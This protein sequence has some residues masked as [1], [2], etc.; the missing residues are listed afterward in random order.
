MSTRIVIYG[1]SGS[2]KTTMAREVAASLGIAHLDL[3]GITWGEGIVR[4]PLAETV[5]LLDAFIDAHESWVIEGCYGDVVEVAA[6]R[7]TELRFLNPGV[8]TCIARCL[9]RPFEPAKFATMEAQNEMLVQLLPWVRAYETRE[10]EY[11]LEKHRAVFE[12]FS[13]TKIEITE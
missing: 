9:K 6:R 8:E 2:G 4:K 5:V 10:D 1:N 3:D 11:G 7:A 13:G 12:A